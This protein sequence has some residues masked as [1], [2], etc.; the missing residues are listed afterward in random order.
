ML[1]LAGSGGWQGGE[2]A[3]AAAASTPPQAVPRRPP[4]LRLIAPHRIAPLHRTTL[5]GGQEA[6]DKIM[7]Y[8]LQP[9]AEAF[10]KLDS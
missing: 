6:V 1:G 3:A 7:G 8:K 2:Q 9:L 4:C 10:K 5:Q